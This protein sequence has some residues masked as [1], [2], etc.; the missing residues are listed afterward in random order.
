MDVD[1]PLVR[2]DLEVLTRVLVLEGAADHAIDV[3]LRGKRHRTGDR[4]PGPLCRLHDRTRRQV[5]LRVVV[6][7]QPDSDLLLSHSAPIAYLMTLVTAPAP[8][9]RPPSRIAKRRPS[10]MAIGWIS[11]TVISAL[12]PG[13]TIST[14]S[15]SSTT[16]VT[17]VVRK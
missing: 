10:S 12:S 4:C 6:P 16:P 5:D 8:T 3:L 2:A 15:F 1:Q 7:L 11:S 9:V 13:M 14:P 17:S